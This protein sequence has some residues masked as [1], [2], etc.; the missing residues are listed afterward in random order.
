MRRAQ[1][2]FIHKNI[3]CVTIIITLEGIQ[4][5]QTEKKN[6][7]KTTKQSEEYFFKERGKKTS[8]NTE[9]AS[10]FSQLNYN[11][12]TL[13]TKASNRGKFPVLILL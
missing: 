5:L 4:K 1:N 9:I 10:T 13:F 6:K 12:T 8:T 2:I 3:D 7:K 11:I